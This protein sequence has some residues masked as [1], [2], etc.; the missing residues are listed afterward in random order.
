QSIE[1]NNRIHRLQRPLL[2]CT[3]LCHDLVG[4]GADEVGR[5]VR[6][7]LLG[8]KRTDLSDRHSTG[9]HGDDLVVETGVTTLVFGDQDGRETTVPVPRNIQSKRAIAG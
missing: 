4:Y 8:K 7:V 2:P 3:D 1:E 6:T 5:N 9:I